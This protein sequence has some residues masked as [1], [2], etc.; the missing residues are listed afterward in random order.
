MITISCYRY[1]FKLDGSNL[2]ENL[3]SSMMLTMNHFPLLQW[4]RNINCIIHQVRHFSNTSRILLPTSSHSIKP[5]KIRWFYATD[6]PDSK[7]FD[8]DYKL[9]KRPTK[10]LPF[11]KTDSNLLENSYQK[12]LKCT[13]DTNNDKK[14]KE[15][16]RYVNVNED[17]LFTADVFKKTLK[18]AYWVGPE[19]EIRRGVWFNDDNQPIPDLLSE[20]IEF[21]Y[22]KYRPDILLTK[23]DDHG[24]KDEKHT[25]P[26]IKLKTEVDMYQSKFREHGKAQKW[27]FEEFNDLSNVEKILY[28]KSDKN[29][30]LVN[31]GQLLPQFFIENFT[32]YSNSIFGLYSF[33]RGY[34]EENNV[35]GELKNKLGN[36][37][38]S[39]KIS[40]IDEAEE[41][42]ADEKFQNI[43]EN[44]FSNETNIYANHKDREV[45]HLILCVHGIGQLL[46]L[47]YTFINFAHDCNHLRQLLKSEFVKKSNTFIPLAYNEKEYEKYKDNEKF[48]NCKVQ[49]LPIVWRHNIDFGLNNICKEYDADGQYRLPKLSDL[50]IDAVTPLRNITADVLL[51]IL[52][53]YEPH[54]KKRIL[55]FVT[56]NVNDI[57]D[58]YLSN[59]PNFKGKISLV[60]HSLGSSI[61]LDILSKQ[62]D[63]IPIKAEFNPKEHLKFN[64]E[65]FFSLGSPNGVFKFMKA[66][67]IHPRSLK[68]EEHLKKHNVVYPK[69]KNFYN[70][71]YATD[72]VAYRIEPLIHT[73]MSK[74]KPKKVELTFEEG[75]IKT[76][77]KDISKVSSDILTS[78]VVKKIVDN[79]TNWQI[80]NNSK[81]DS[82][83]NSSSGS[84]TDS[85]TGL[86]VGEESAIDT[87]KHVKELMFGLNKNGRVDYV[88]PQG[89]FEID[90][91][92]AVGSH[93]QYFDDPDV[94][95]FILGELWKPNNNNKKLG[96]GDSFVGV[97]VGEV[98]NNGKEKKPSK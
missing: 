95:N 58:K 76:K 46:S 48:K 16:L 4:G 3:E 21:Y 19:Y 40:K 28:F 11:T 7:P 12:Y 2:K 29:A 97:P 61:V 83:S 67:N 23:N 56:E 27:P 92:N 80:I 85:K 68:G 73:S 41:N 52:L 15:E 24:D 60:G 72:L 86:F 43:M 33:R 31:K 75:L 94:A 25:L 34:K 65:N 59:N 77:I 54:F 14:L 84:N 17:G 64:V 69:V 96:K 50:N 26:G 44:D 62:P 30:I 42:K 1:F 91:I 37:S 35:V 88:L 32:G 66:Q 38:E 20:Q 36:V 70:I 78:T 74:I 79:T 98:D 57:Y 8:P 89:M 81:S 82:N 49:I 63:K 39:S 51:D 10:F 93:V 53:F 6:I 22:A 13:S 87:S 55:E 18:P 5:V 45:D 71:F 90:I 47:K 9:L